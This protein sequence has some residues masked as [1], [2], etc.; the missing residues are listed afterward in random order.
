MVMPLHA[1]RL[2]ALLTDHHSVTPLQTVDAEAK[3]Q[4][5]EAK[6]QTPEAKSQTP[7]AKS[8]TPEACEASEVPQINGIKVSDVRSSDAVFCLALI[9]HFRGPDVIYIHLSA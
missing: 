7:E 8:Q 9:S 2:L 3:S 1:M 6:S 4:T 5:P